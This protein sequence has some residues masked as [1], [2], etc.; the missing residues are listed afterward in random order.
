M[1][2]PLHQPLVH[3]LVKE[4]H[5]LRSVLQHISDNVFQHALRQYHIILQIRKCHFRLNHPEFR[6]MAG[7]IG[8]LRPE[9]GAEGV[10]VFKCKGIRFAVQLSADGKIGGLAEEVLAKVHLSLLGLGNVVQIQSSHL[11]HLPCPLAVAACDQRGMDIHEASLVEKAVNGIGNQGANTKDCLKG[12]GSGAQMR[13]GP[14]IL[15]AMTLLLQ[16]I[17]RSG[18]AFHH[19]LSCLHLKGLLCAGGLHNGSPQDQGRPHIDFAQRIEIGQ[20]IAVNHLKRLKKGSVIHH[21]ESKILGIPI[22]PDPAAN[23]HL[24]ADVLLFPAI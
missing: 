19:R 15:K 10:Y 8:I 17:L 4:S 3:E 11:K 12:I 18:S 22:A 20:R 13:N 16:R 9:G 24:L 21:Q 5:L 2:Q 6:C 7:G 14:Q 23:G 1:I